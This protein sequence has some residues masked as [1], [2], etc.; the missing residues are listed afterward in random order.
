M[1]ADHKEMARKHADNVAK[2]KAA[3]E[4]AAAAAAAVEPQQPA[5]P[6]VCCDDAVPLLACKAEIP[7]S[8]KAL[9]T[10]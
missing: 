5:G 2:R 10:G 6:K 8:M 3:A 4:A 1:R 9:S 7:K